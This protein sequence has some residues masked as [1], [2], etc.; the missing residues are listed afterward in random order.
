MT[1]GPALFAD[2]GDRLA[3]AGSLTHLG[4]NHHA[5]GNSPASADP[6]TS[7]PR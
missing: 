6:R 5:A 4:D 2:L 1:A 7:P 3:E